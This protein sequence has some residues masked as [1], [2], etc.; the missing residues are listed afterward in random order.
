[1]WYLKPGY[2]PFRNYKEKR[3]VVHSEKGGVNRFDIESK[4]YMLAQDLRK[5]LK[6]ELYLGFEQP[7]LSKDSARWLQKQ[8]TK[9]S[10]TFQGLQA[11]AQSSKYTINITHSILTKTPSKQK[12]TRNRGDAKLIKI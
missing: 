7:S 3:S 9:N 4:V 11:K 1:M 5:T 2:V 8:I 10:K 12:N 6:Q